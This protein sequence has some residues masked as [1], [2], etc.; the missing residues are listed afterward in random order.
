MAKLSLTDIAAGFGL[1]ATY[2]ANNALLEAALENTLSRDGTAPNTMSVDIDMNSQRVVNLNDGINNQ[3]A[4]TL[5]QLNT[6]SIVVSTVAA[7]AATLADAGG[8]YVSSTVEAAFAE[9]FEAPSETTRRVLELATQAETNTGTDDTRVITPLKLANATSLLQATE[10]Q[11][12]ALEIATSA[13]VITGTDNTRAV[14]PAGL[15]ALT[16][17]ETRDG[18]IELATQAEVDAGVDAVRAV[19]PATLKLAPPP[20]SG[21]GARGALAFGNSNQSTANTVELTVLL[22][23]EAYDTDTVHS[24]SVNTSRL[25]VPS[26]VTKIRLTAQI[27]FAGNSTGVTRRLRITKNGG[28]GGIDANRDTYLPVIEAAAAGTPDPLG[29]QIVTG[30]IETVATDFFE[31]KVLQ[32]SGGA[33]NLLADMYWFEMEILE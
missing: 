22:D 25:T 27:Q 8:F 16:T 17:S 13:E 18:L 12:G 28:G 21:A 9:L 33:L 3:D 30:V 10:T 7:S 2:N 20:A 6:A 11:K 23:S 19:T 26:G 32:N 4:V 15:A 29:I 5:S 14:T 1:I 31:M 24:T